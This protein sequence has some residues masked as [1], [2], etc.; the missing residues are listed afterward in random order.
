MR[1]NDVWAYKSPRWLV[2]AGSSLV[3][4]L[5]GDLLSVSRWELASDAR[6]HDD[7]FSISCPIHTSKAH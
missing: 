6:D 4:T 2:G 3:T 5:L 7:I 1:A